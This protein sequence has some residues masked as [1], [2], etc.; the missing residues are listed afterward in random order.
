[1]D[2]KIVGNELREY[3]GSAKH[4]VIPDGVRFICDSAFKESDI[5]SVEFPESVEF[6]KTAAFA[7]CQ[8]LTEITLPKTIYSVGWYAFY[9]CRNL[10]RVHLKNGITEVHYSA[11]ED[12]VNLQYINIPSSLKIASIDFSTCKNLEEVHLGSGITAIGAGTFKGCE[13][14]QNINLENVTSIGQNAFKGCSLLVESVNGV[15][16]LDNWV[17]GSDDDITVAD[18]AEGTIGIAA[19]AFYQFEH[20]I[21]VNVPKSV[22]YM[23]TDA[24]CYA[25]VYIAVAEEPSTWKTASGWQNCCREIVWDTSS[26]RTDEQGI[27]YRLHDNGT[28]SVIK[29][30]GGSQSLVIASQV[31]DHAV[32]VI[33]S[34]SFRHLQEIP[35]VTIPDSVKV[36]ESGAFSLYCDAYKWIDGV[37]Y[38]D[39][40]VMAYDTNLKDIT[41]RLPI[42]G[43][44]QK[45]FEN[46]RLVGIYA[47]EEGKRVPLPDVIKQGFC[48][49]MYTLLDTKIKG[50]INVDGKCFAEQNYGYEDS[51]EIRRQASCYGIYKSYS[52]DKTVWANS[53]ENSYT[54]GDSTT[55][56]NPKTIVVHN[57]EFIGVL[58]DYGR[59]DGW[60]CPPSGKVFLSITDKKMKLTEKYTSR[61]SDMEET[62]HQTYARLVKIK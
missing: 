55:S 4:V 57:G 5:V 7:H 39:G 13:K 52:D 37:A 56:I 33:K 59:S 14:L 18:I 19:R 62:D 8:G 26:F 29:Y 46:S 22:K 21:T 53:S 27:V 24:I 54:S 44:V 41:I 2:F 12:C 61:Y 1:M 31:E 28:A 47:E 48:I 49:K 20:Y 50:A 42:R 16:Y 25:D 43:I 9:N 34:D 60:Y 40:W 15:H 36:V 11:F 17:V 38:L 58:L 6:I 30:N 3:L 32:T 10:K 23:G 51:L 35:Q 45:F